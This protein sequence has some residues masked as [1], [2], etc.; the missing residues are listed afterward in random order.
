MSNNVLNREEEEEEEQTT[1]IWSFRK[2]CVVSLNKQNTAIWKKIRVGRCPA[3]LI[4][5]ICGRSGLITKR[6]PE[7]LA[8]IICGLSHTFFPPSQ[9]LSMADGVM[10]EPY[11]R[12]WFADDILHRPINEVGVAIWN[13]NPILCN[14]LDGET[15]DDDGSDAAI[16]IKIPGKINRKYIDVVMS[17]GKKLNNPHPESYIYHN[18]YDQITMGSVITNKKGCY[19][20]VC[21][22]NDGTA[23][24][25]YLDTDYDLW[26]TILYPK[27]KTFHAKYI[28]PLL[29]K[30]NIQVIMPPTLSKNDD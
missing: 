4:S 25:Q 3:S 8:S 9:Q 23:F 11:V 2:T 16:E 26:D 24:Y 14:S 6:T 28:M 13:E 10:G 22:L 7:E 1:P 21:C 30:H 20:V 27:A 19:Y 17:W 12:Q 18:H 29:I 15:T 5:E